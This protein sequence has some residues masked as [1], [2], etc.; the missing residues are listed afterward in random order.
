MRVRVISITVRP[1]LPSNVMSS[2]EASTAS[3]RPH[4][5]RSS[6]ASATTTTAKTAT[7][8][9]RKVHVSN[10]Q[11]LAKMLT[12]CSTIICYCGIA[13]SPCNSK[14]FVFEVTPSEAGTAESELLGI[15][16]AEHF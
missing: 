9:R 11:Y 1:V 16:A 3:F 14:A 12:H 5:D 8:R 10:A 7:T 2:V 4:S 15:A 6:A 13:R